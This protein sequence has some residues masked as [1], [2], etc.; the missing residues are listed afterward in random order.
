[1]TVPSQAS[2]A[3]QEPTDMPKAG[4]V[5]ILKRSV[6]QFKH[7][8]ITDRAA[9]LTYFGV[10]AIFPGML[11]LVSIMGLVGQSTTQ[12]VLDNISQVA[13]GGVTDFL[14]TV[15]TQVQG[16]AGA[17]SIAAILGLVLAVWAASAYVAAFIRASNAIYEVDE[18]RPIWK[19]LPLRLMLTLAV[20][21]ML[22]IC[23]VIITV[24]GP[25]AT[26]VGEAFGIGDALVLTWNIAKWP[27]LIIVVSLMFS[28]LYTASPNVK[29]PP[30][31]WITLGGVIAVVLWLV[32][33]LLFAVYVAFSGSYNR[34][35]G[36]LA[37]V[38]IFLV[39]LWISNIAILLGL[40]FDAETQRERAIRAGMP[41]HVEPFTDLRDTRKLDEA[42]QRRVEEASRLRGGADH[43]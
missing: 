27:V 4:W 43:D 15:I 34:T 17:A 31:R 12:T 30:F 2:Q 9:A 26:Q 25:V 41:E 29:Q 32:S 19:T 23:V 36:S 28:L 42:E 10:L 33:S 38:I 13:P 14:G 39:W 22:V 18:G 7:D 8:D 16:K 24:T 5:S 20:V 6:K 35:Y 37:T 21:V 1:M 11:V 40:E 3:P